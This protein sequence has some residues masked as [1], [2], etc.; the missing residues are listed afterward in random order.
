[1]FRD[2]K[3]GNRLSEGHQSL[4]LASSARLLAPSLTA[5][6]TLPVAIRLPSIPLL[7]ASTSN[8][9]EPTASRHSSSGCQ[10]LRWRIRKPCPRRFPFGCPFV[11]QSSNA[12]GLRWVPAG[13]RY[14]VQLK[15]K[16]AY[17]P[18]ERISF[19]ANDGKL[20][21]SLPSHQRRNAMPAVLIVGRS[22][23]S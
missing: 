21:E 1:M 10:R 6:L 15:G 3:V 13:V 12:H 8:L 17:K 2:E 16:S 9:S 18:F 22:Q 23:V 14:R 7:W 4:R 20:F 11:D 5:S 19:P